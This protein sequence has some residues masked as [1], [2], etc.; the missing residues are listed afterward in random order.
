M[1]SNRHRKDT[2]AP[3]D[4]EQRSRLWAEENKGSQSPQ[5]HEL[6]IAARKGRTNDIERILSE[7]GGS[8]S[9]NITDRVS[10]ITMIDLITLSV[11]FT[12]CLI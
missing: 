9:T 2:P 12:M 4:L 7:K 10:W 11:W 8:T 3:G 5:I 1:A 6:L